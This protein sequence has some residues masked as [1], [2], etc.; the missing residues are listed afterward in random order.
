MSFFNIAGSKDWGTTDAGEK[1]WET[2][3]KDKKNNENGKRKIKVKDK[4]GTINRISANLLNKKDE[5]LRT[6]KKK[7]L[8]PSRPDEIP[9]NNSYSP[10]DYHMRHNKKNL[11]RKRNGSSI[12]CKSTAKKAK[13]E[14]TGLS[15]KVIPKIAAK[16]SKKANNSKQK[17]LKSK[18][19]CSSKNGQNPNTSFDTP[20]TQKSKQ[21]LKKLKQYLEKKGQQQ[22]PRPKL[23]EKQSNLPLRERMMRKLQA[24]RFRYL[25][26]QIYTT[27]GNQTE[28]AFRRDPEAFKAYHEG[29]KLQVKRWPLNPLDKIIKSVLKMDKNLVIADFGCGEAKLAQ[30]VDQKVHSFDLVAANQ[31]VTACDMA[32][33]PLSDSSVDIVVFCLSLMGTNLGDYLLEANRVLKNGGLLKI[34]EV[35]SRFEDVDDFVKKCNKYGFKKTWMDLSYNLFYFIDFRK[36]ASVGDKKKLP[37]IALQPCLYK[38][39]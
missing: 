17:N 18:E 28:K 5:M 4:K 29:Y 8:K 39:R 26:E 9:L 19:S 30:S 2:F 16:V 22:L 38:K 36:I 10:E 25:N 35:E 27:T 1:L 31:E 7:I 15:T 21:K 32:H 12:L 11:K 13:K 3:N 20:Q 34:S 14:I 6:M 23:T 33:V 24:A 37:A